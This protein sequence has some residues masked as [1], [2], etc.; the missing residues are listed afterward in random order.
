MA[1][2]NRPNPLD[3]TERFPDRLRGRKPALF[4]DYDG[5]LTPIVPRPEDAIMSD[6]MRER[7]RRL[8]TLCPVAVVSGR[9]RKVVEQF[10]RLEGIHYAG[11]HGF[12][13]HGPG[14]AMEHPAAR[15]ALPELDQ[16]ERAL[17]ERLAEIPGAQLERKKFAIAAHYRNAAPVDAVRVERAV[18]EVHREH[19]GL[20]KRGG[21]MVFELQPNVDWDKGQAVLWLLDALGLDGP[22]VLPI[23]I[24]DDLTDEDAFRA[25]KGRG[26][27][28]RVGESSEETEADYLLKDPDEVP[29]FLEMLAEY[30]ESRR[31][32]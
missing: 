29:A 23:F 7:V 13:I 10:V 6:E 27:G 14:V 22:E 17:A 24:G 18:D 11:S 3:E 32:S 1:Q 21:K 16:A 28:I 15:K 9:D 20:R 19:P 26:I 8:A 25:L 31:S 4:L 5:T 2:T 12:D 30:L